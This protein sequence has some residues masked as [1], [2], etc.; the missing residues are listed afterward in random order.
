MDGDP[1][2]KQAGVD[3]GSLAIGSVGDDLKDCCGSL[4]TG[5]FGNQPAINDGLVNLLKLVTPVPG[6]VLLS[7]HDRRVVACDINVDQIML[8]IRLPGTITID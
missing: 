5:T 7:Q 4:V 3:I 2:I 6:T 1:R 8:V